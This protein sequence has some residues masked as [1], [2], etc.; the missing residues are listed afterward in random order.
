M[1]HF[2]PEKGSFLIQKTQKTKAATRYLDQMGTNQRTNTDFEK[3]I[4]I[5]PQKA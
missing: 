1:A 2:A 3:L 5:D 4:K